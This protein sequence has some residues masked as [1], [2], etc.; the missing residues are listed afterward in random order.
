MVT[1]FLGKD[2]ETAFYRLIALIIYIA[3]FIMTVII[4]KKC[5]TD[6][7]YISLAIDFVGI[8]ILMF[9]PE[10]ID[11]VIALFPIFFMSAFQYNAFA[12]IKNYNCAT[13]FSTNNL[14][15]MVI[16]FTEYIT[17]KNKEELDRGKFFGATLLWYHVGVA[18]AFF[19]VKHLGL[20]G[21]IVCIPF[22]ILATSIMVMKKSIK[23]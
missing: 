6:V 16:G 3:A 14:R 20:H 19:A 17:D 8:I 23:R 18:V 5:K 13:I 12:K 7:R 15:Q 4:P 2:M 21:I 22:I 9:I 1:S 10:K 11:P